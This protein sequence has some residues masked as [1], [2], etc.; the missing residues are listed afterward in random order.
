MEVKP[1]LDPGGLVTV[2][3]LTNRAVP[4]SR[5]L[6]EF[7]VNHCEELTFARLSVCPKGEGL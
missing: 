7:L 5:D 6:F 2:F 4:K 3:A 1:W